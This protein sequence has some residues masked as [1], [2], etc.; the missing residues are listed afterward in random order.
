M[1]VAVGCVGRTGLWDV[2]TG[3]MLLQSGGARASGVAFSHDCGTLAISGNSP[4]GSQGVEVTRLANGRGLQTL[5]GLSNQVVK[6]LYSGDV[7]EIASGKQITH[8]PLPAGFVDHIGFDSVGEKLVLFRVESDDPG[9]PPWGAEGRHRPKVCWIRH[10]KIGKEPDPVR[11]ISDF[12]LRVF[13]ATCPTDGSYFIIDGKGSTPKGE[14]RWVKAFDGSS[15]RLLWTRESQRTALNAQVALDASGKEVAVA[16]VDEA[17]KDCDTTLIDVRS[18]RELESL[19]G[20]LESNLAPGSGA[21]LPSG[22][23]Y[24]G[25]GALSQ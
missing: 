11:R 23:E 6:V 15:G 19:T 12:T 16:L 18:G 9:I 17:G 13:G 20:R 22:H 7:W 1:T 2:A 4:F 5:R 24:H 25:T 3:R 14:Q 21:R 8:W 10:L